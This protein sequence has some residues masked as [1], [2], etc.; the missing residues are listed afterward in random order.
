[1]EI[2]KAIDFVNS[3]D[4]EFGNRHYEIHGLSVSKASKHL[5]EKRIVD[6]ASNIQKDLMDAWLAQW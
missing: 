4:D 6:I 5:G 3:P 2:E 1:M